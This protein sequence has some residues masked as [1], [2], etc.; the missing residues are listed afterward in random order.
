MVDT[1]SSFTLF[2]RKD[3][4]V[5]QHDPYC[6]VNDLNSEVYICLTASLVSA[7]VL[8]TDAVSPTCFHRKFV[9]CSIIIFSNQI[10]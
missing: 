5:T 7:I 9:N 3:S 1:R 4:L 8:P 2:S 6:S 10:V